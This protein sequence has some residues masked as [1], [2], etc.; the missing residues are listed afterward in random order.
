[1]EENLEELR[2]KCKNQKTEIEH[3][4]KK[5]SI[6]CRE[7]T[8]KDGVL[9][10]KN[11][12]LDAVGF[13]W[14]SGGCEGGVF[15]YDDCT[16]AED[17]VRLVERNTK[18]LREWLNNRKCREARDTGVPKEQCSDCRSKETCFPEGNE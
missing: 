14:C 16:L 6:L 5:C 1:M 10:R 18:R 4:R 9:L 11:R 8:D 13:V 2:E 15:R 7:I 12:E 3:L 17:Q